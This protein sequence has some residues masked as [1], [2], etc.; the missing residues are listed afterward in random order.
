MIKRTRYLN[1]VLPCSETQNA[2]R[3][4]QNTIWE[5]EARAFRRKI[6]DLN[7]QQPMHYE[8]IPVPFSPMECETQR[9]GLGRSFVLDGSCAALCGYCWLVGL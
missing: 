9:T 4:L 6:Q 7:R 1:S 8:R 2:V 5:Y 3:W